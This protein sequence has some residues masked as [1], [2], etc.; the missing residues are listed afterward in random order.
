MYDDDEPDWTALSDADLADIALGPDVWLN[1][2]ALSELADRS[3]ETARPVALEALT[4]SDTLLAAMALRV[5]AESDLDEALRYMRRTVLVAPLSILDAMVDVLAVEHPIDPGHD[6]N[7][8]AEL[9]K[10]LWPPAGSREYNLADLLFRQY[11]ELK[12]RPGI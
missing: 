8:L 1:V 6:K 7:L 12:P 10:R 4:R 2:P 5:L 11:P 9:V 3:P